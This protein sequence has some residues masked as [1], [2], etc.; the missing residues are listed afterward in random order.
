MNGKNLFTALS[1]IHERFVDEAMNEEV[2]NRKVSWLGALSLAACLCLICIWCIQPFFSSHGHPPETTVPIFYP[3]GDMCAVVRV[4]SMTEHGIRATVTETAFPDFFQVGSQ[5]NVEP[6]SGT[7]YEFT[8]GT[9][10]EL[11]GN[12]IDLTGQCVWV[13]ITD[14]HGD[15]II[16]DYIMEVSEP[17]PTG[18]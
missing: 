6:E 2:T 12:R 14:V 8:D 18:D 11:D 4:E 10:M 13:Q 3:E 7:I 5:W 1:F 16:V 15:T 17:A 9:C